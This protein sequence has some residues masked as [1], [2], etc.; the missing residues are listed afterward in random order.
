MIRD[1]WQEGKYTC[2]QICR[3]FYDLKNHVFRT[4]KYRAYLLKEDLDDSVSI[5]DVEV[6][7]YRQKV[8]A[9]PVTIDTKIQNLKLD[10]SKN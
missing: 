4:D 7:T 9:L 6:N 5:D 3:G 10:L 2:E 8:Q 1:R